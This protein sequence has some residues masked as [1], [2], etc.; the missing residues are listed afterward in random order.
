MKIFLMVLLAIDML[1]VIVVMLVGA[2]GLVDANRSGR[3]S[4]MLM[5]LRVGLQAVAIGLV[6]LLMMTGR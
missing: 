6:V 5:R 4:N 3:T 2:I 1:A